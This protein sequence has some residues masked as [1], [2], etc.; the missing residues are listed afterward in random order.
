MLGF[1]GTVPSDEGVRL[2]AKQIEEEKIGGV[3]LLQR[4]TKDGPKVLQDLTKYLCQSIPVRSKP[5]LVAIDGEGGKVKRLTKEHGY[6]ELPTAKEMA[7][8][9]SKDFE[10]RLNP[11]I[12][13]LKSLGINWNLAPVVDIEVEKEKGCI[14]R[15]KRS[16]S[17]N[18]EEVKKFVAKVV[19]AH[20]KQGLAT[21]FKHWP[22]LGADMGDTHQGMTDLTKV[23]DKERDEA[24]FH[25]VIQWFKERKFWQKPAVM[26][27]HSIHKG[28]DSESPSLTFS[29]KMIAQQREKWGLDNLFVSDDLDM[30]ALDAYE[31]GD[32]VVR[33]LLAGNDIVIISQYRNY[34]SEKVEKIQEHIMKIL[35]Q[36]TDIAAKLEQRINES[37]ERVQ[38]FKKSWFQVDSI[39]TKGSS[40]AKVTHE[41]G[42]AEPF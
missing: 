24:P 10:S 2:V 7:A 40:S 22:G 13:Q 31:I 20:I 41:E 11:Y 27:A 4:N 23:W 15:L 25:E 12:A 17:E 21:C 1:E 32:K 30:G 18:P 38:A 26:T 29:E 19:E 37:Y 16:Y 14:G 36:Q 28:L 5:L 8:L 33:A 39:E 42:N 9:S 34:D 6:I 3:L 35:A